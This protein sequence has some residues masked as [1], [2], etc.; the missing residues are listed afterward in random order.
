M[1]I[2][3]LGCG[4]SSGVPMIGCT[5]EICT[6]PNPKN[7]R[8]R[9]SVYIK[10]GDDHI[11]IDTS[12]DLR[13]QALEQHVIRLDAILYTHAHADHHHGIDDVRSF[14]HLANKALP[15]YS[16]AETITSIR[17]R[18]DYCFQEP[19]PE[20][21]WFRPVLIPHE[22]TFGK[23]FFVG[24]TEII[25]FEQHHGRLPSIGFR[26]GNFAYS[27][28]VRKL[29]ESSFA[30]LEGITHW[31]VDCLR[32]DPAP[33]H[34]HLAQTLEW[35]ARV[36]PAHAYLTHMGHHLEYEA[37]KKSLPAGVE[38]AYDGLSITL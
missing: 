28:D 34:A 9:A 27:T 37:L 25:P 29:P 33:T 18:F 12:P 38:P 22:I 26:V 35:I 6:S 5:C 36:K 11:L 8:T 19:K 24:K 2:I 32:S 16:D 30:I 1:K 3:V 7:K 20:Y 23:P 21:G 14:N 17:N 4:A 31:V 13:F 15:I 10:S